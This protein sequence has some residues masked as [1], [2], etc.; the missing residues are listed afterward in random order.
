[1]CDVRIWQFQDFAHAAQM[2][3]SL[4]TMDYPEVPYSD[5]FN[6]I[7]LVMFENARTFVWV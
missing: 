6:A 3:M 4:V 5:R 2:K 7:W 1:M